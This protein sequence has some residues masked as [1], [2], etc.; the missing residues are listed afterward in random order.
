MR[1]GGVRWVDGSG[2]I[3][4]AYIILVREI[5][6]GGHLEHLNGDAT[7][8][9]RY[10]RFFTANLRA[11]WIITWLD[12]FF[13]ALKKDEITQIIEQMVLFVTRPRH[14]IRSNLLKEK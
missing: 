8:I 14:I 10:L 3:R 5:W 13:L 9:L 7:L 2:A 4:N 12:V 1:W 6:E 11:D